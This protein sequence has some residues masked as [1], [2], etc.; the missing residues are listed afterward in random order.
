MLFQKRKCYMII[1]E[2]I[3]QR[4]LILDGASGTMIQKYKLSEEEYRGNKFISHAINLKGCNDILNISKPEIIKQITLAYLNAGADIVCT[5]TFNAQSVSLSD[6]GLEQYAYEINLASAKLVKETVKSFVKQ[7]SGRDC[8]VAGSIG[9]TNRTASISSDVNNPAFR[10]VTFDELVIAYTQQVE[11]LMDGEVDLLILETVFDTLNV[12]AALYAITEVFENKR[13]KI[14]VIVSV[15]ISDASGRTLSGQTLEAFLISVSHFP[16][17]SVGL[18]CALGA[19]QMKPFVAFLAEKAPFNI[20]LYPNAG[21]PNQLGGYDEK[22]EEMVA[23]MEQYMNN[24][25]VNMVGGC[26]GT[27]PD[28]IR[29]LASKSKKYKPRQIPEIPVTTKLSGLEPV[30]LYSGCNFLNIGERTNVA[31]SKKFADLIKEQKYEEALSVAKQQIEGGAQVIDICM[32]DAM[33]D[34]EKSMVTFLNL[35]AS[36]P[37]I[38]KVPI[39]ID[40]SK[41]NVIE[42]GLKCVQ[43]KSIVNSISLK[44]GEAIFKKQATYIKQMGSAMIVMAFDENGQAVSFNHKIKICERAYK[45]LVN[46]IGVSPE[47]IIF[48]PNILSIATGIEEHNNY[49]LDFIKT[50]QWIKENLPFA[51]VSGGVSNLSFSFRGNE[52]VRRAM[53]SVFLYHAVKAGM[54]MGIVNPAQL[55]IYDEINKDLLPIIED[56]ILNKNTSATEKLIDFAE[57]NKNVEKKEENKEE[58]R[59]GKVQDRLR[60]AIVKGVTTYIEQDVEEARLFYKKAFQVIEGPL[61]DAMNVVGSLFGSGKM[62][63]PQVVKSA[64]VMKKAVAVLLPYLEKEK[65]E[66]SNSAVKKILLATVKGDVHDIGKNMVGVILSCNNYEVK[67]LGVMVSTEKIIDAVETYKPDVLGLSGLITPSLEEM[68]HVAKEMEKKG[69]KIPIIIG[70]ATTS[71]IHT[72]VKIAP[73]YSAPVVHVKDASQSVSV[74]A[75]MLSEKNASTFFKEINETYHKIRTDYMN[76][77]NPTLISLTEARNNKF[78]IDVKKHPVKVPLN[79]GIRVFENFSLE[80]LADFIDWSYFFKEWRIN[81]RFPEILNDSI[82]GTEASK[83]FDDAQEM[84]KDLIKESWITANGVI[85]IFPCNSVDEDIEVYQHDNIKKRVTKFNFIRNQ[86][87]QENKPNYC[88]SDFVLPKESGIIDYVGCFAVSTG[89]NIEKKINEFSKALDD[90]SAFM[91]KILADRLADAFS[92]YLHL[93]VRKEIW[94]Y[95]PNEELSVQDIWLKKYSGIKVSPGYPACPDHIGKR[96]I[97]NLLEVENKTGIKLTENYM[98]NPSASI[99][100]WYFASEDAPYF[101]IGKISD[102]QLEV[103]AIRKNISMEEAKKWLTTLNN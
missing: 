43:G 53:H 29:L 68:V 74:V 34:A 79:N 64:R 58:W 49:A 12:K 75:S 44:E 19:A 99:C 70:G 89:L 14:P 16:L 90:Y 31:G 18:N 47:D 100:G 36:E 57:K 24:G 88:L 33:I 21:L 28:H 25:L 81:G 13:K 10:A 3:K 32:D 78:V 42:A 27:T 6:Y 39:M 15:T 95:A 101:S 4:I 22:P 26:C 65:E 62:F 60:H 11:G 98:M 9:P 5:N 80:I 87:K 56:V 37:D 2:L 7:N 45:I 1:E 102:E 66:N 20:S 103:Y 76:K 63:L 40:S 35:I 61:M 96:E 86:Q 8:F 85:G 97:F 41:W 69:F 93:L 84:L 38:S 50:V 48:D 30:E 82:K 73:Y 59:K 92:E 83:L 67:D 54:D 23:I 91:L 94:G 55:D 46:E 71:P 72:A 51:K 17:F 52:M 77:E